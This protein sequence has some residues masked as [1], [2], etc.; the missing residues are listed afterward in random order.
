M[1]SSEVACPRKSKAK[2]SVH[3]SDSSN[4]DPMAVHR[5]PVSNL[6]RDDWT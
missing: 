5:S 1:V 6:R 4:E 3:L 2:I